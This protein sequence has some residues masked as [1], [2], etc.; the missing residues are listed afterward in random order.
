MGP[1]AQP[2]PKHP[3]VQS[4]FPPCPSWEGMGAG[5]GMGS[6]RRGRL[7]VRLPPARGPRRGSPPR[8]YSIRCKITEQGGSLPAPFPAT[9]PEPPPPLPPLP[10]P[11]WHRTHGHGRSTAAGSLSPSGT[12]LCPQLPQWVLGPLAPCQTSPPASHGQ[13]GWGG[14]VA[15]APSQNIPPAP[16][17]PPCPGRVG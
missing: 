15:S 13:L 16:A 8:N 6:R 3:G 14:G 9:L 11:S 5:E 2:H 7:R 1:H 12:G 17:L 10:K 4:G